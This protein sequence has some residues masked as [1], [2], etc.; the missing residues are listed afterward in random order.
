MNEH[1]FAIFQITYSTALTGVVALLS[2]W[3]KKHMAKISNDKKADMLVLRYVLIQ[4]HDIY[5]VKGYITRS[6]LQTFEEIWD[7]YHTG[8]GGNTLT[9]RFHDEVT[10]LKIIMD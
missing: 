5:V 10:K 4:M 1:V 8:Y 7:L 2:L 6:A 9:D 3:I